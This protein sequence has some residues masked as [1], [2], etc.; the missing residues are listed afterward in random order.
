MRLII[1]D[2]TPAQCKA[3]GI[4]D[5]SEKENIIVDSNGDNHYCIGCFGCWL[6]TPGRCVIKDEYQTMGE[7]L[8]KVEELLIISKSSFGSYSSSVKNV[9]DR[10]ISYVMPFF[11]IRNGEMHH[12][13][14]YRKNLV[15]SA[16][17]YGD[18]ITEAE[19]DTSR[20]LVEANAVNLNGTVGSVQF[21]DK[22]ENCRE[23]LV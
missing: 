17:F 20:K 23:V 21:L 13:E 11:E 19:K 14:R 3:S 9:L 2:L 22:P 18:D 4:Y 1:H 10:S 15:I 16:Y 5:L 12:Q 6:K 7:K 8:S